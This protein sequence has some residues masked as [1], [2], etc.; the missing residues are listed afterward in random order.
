MQLQENNQLHCG[1]MYLKLFIF[2]NI[3]KVLFFQTMPDNQKQ[4]H[5]IVK[6]AS[7]WLLQSD[8]TGDS[9]HKRYINNSLEEQSWCQRLEVY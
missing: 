4:V 8:D 7:Y 3:S 6:Q 2:Q 9:F 5:W 1:V